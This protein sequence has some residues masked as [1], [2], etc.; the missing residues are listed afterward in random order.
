MSQRLFALVSAV[1]FL[2][3]ALAHLLRVIVQARA[4][5]EG[6]AVPMWMSVVAVAVTGYLS[7]QG[8]RLAGRAGKVQD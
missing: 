7:F 5:V 1:L 3:I 8:F 6:Y 2:F 4:T